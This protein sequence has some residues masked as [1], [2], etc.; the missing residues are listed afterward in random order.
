M[1]FN[2]PWQGLDPNGPA[3]YHL[4]GRILSD[5]STDLVMLSYRLRG[6]PT[7]KPSLAWKSPY[8]PAGKALSDG[9]KALSARIYIIGRLGTRYYHSRSIR[10]GLRTML[11]ALTR[12]TTN[13]HWP[14]V[15]YW[16]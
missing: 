11:F 1:L 16:I 7:R 8:Y 12:Q 4:Q 13:R 5:T 15:L 9:R 6:L 10:D 2:G 14:G 3:L